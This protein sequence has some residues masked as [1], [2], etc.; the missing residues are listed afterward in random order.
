LFLQCFEGTCVALVLLCRI[1]HTK[2]VG[3]ADG[4]LETK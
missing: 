2:P 4:N 1:G 3:A